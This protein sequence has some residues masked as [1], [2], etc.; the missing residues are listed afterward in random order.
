[1]NEPVGWFDEIKN[2][3]FQTENFGEIQ[4]IRLYEKK[5]KKKA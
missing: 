1:M 4:K 2:C 5:R 3:A